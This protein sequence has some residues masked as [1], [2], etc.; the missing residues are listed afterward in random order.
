MVLRAGFAALPSLSEPPKGS[1]LHYCF[2]RVSTNEVWPNGPSPDSL[3]CRHLAG[4]RGRRGKLLSPCVTLLPPP[5]LLQVV[6]TC[7]DSDCSGCCSQNA[8]RN[9]GFLIDLEYHTAKRFWGGKI[10][11][12]AVIEW[13]EV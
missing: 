8:N 6:D 13:Q 7:D 2:C 3:E 12:M 10:N 4:R 11:G 5:L 1:L 9:G